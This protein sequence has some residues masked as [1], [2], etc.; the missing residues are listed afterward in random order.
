MLARIAEQY[1]ACPRALEI[2]VRGMLPGEAHAS[3]NLDILG[4]G[5][6]GGF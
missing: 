4:C 2:Q 1:R 5:V 6:T 3:V